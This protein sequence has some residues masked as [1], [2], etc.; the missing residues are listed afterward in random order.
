MQRWFVIRTRTE[1]FGMGSEDGIVI[2]VPEQHSWMLQKTLQ[3][4]KPYLSEHKAKVLELKPT[5]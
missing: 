5:P 2:F 1:C 4:I 3:E